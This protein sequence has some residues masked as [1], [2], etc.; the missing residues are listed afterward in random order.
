MLFDDPGLQ[1]LFALLPTPQQWDLHDYYRTN[2]RLDEQEFLAVRRAT[3]TASPSLAHRA[4]KSFRI[5][6]DAFVAVSRMSDQD[7]RTAVAHAVQSST[8]P[9]G[10]KAPQAA[11]HEVRV[12]PIAKPLD[13]ERVAR[14]FIALAMFQNQ[15]SVREEL[16]E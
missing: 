5:I 4:G 7:I 16:D 12:V 14:A 1:V 6:E 3:D 13:V 11:S 15:S 10:A 9:S 2:G 8:P